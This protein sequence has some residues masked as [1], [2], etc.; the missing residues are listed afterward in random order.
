MS[1]LAKTLQSAIDRSEVAF[2]AFQEAT[3]AMAK[4]NAQLGIFH[5]TLNQA[6]REMQERPMTGLEMDLAELAN[7]KAELL[8]RMAL[9]HLRSSP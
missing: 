3:R 7:A 8:G 1:D 4:A 6:L 5:D 9:I 2:A